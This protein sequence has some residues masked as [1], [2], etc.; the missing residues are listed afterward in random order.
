[1]AVKPTPPQALLIECRDPLL[2]D[3]PASDNDV[4][5]DMVR[6]AQ[7]YVDCKQRQSDLS[8][9]VKGALK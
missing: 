4:A 9:W 2:I 3:P 7:A 1:M 8:K 6:M 5:I